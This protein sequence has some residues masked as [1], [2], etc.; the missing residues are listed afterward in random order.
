[1]RGDDI[2]DEEEAALD[3]E[4]NDDGPGLRYQYH[5]T[6][7]GDIREYWIGDGKDDAYVFRLLNEVLAHI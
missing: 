2:D 7:L 5:E 1:V 4:V 3:D 6:V